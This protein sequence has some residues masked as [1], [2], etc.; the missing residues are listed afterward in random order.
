MIV[1]FLITI[2]L[3]TITR[4]YRSIDLTMKINDS[5]VDTILTN[6]NADL[7]ANTDYTYSILTMANNNSTI[8]LIVIPLLKLFKMS[9]P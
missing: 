6:T 1:R 3:I 7:L 9:L 2:T 4:H 5:Y 8:N